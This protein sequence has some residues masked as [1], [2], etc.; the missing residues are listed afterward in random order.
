MNKSI[1]IIGAGN[2]GTAI[3]EGLLKSKFS[4][5]AEIV[6]TRRNISI[7]PLKALGINITDNNNAAV[8]KSD[9]IILAVKP[10]QTLELLKAIRKEI[11]PGK[12]VISVV[13]GITIQEIE[14]SIGSQVSL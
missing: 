14:N 3:A 2:L 11:T 4:K 6:V 7:N 8:K 12:I 5:A 9:V 10:F 1:A 13:T